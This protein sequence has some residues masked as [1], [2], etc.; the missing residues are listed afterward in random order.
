MEFAIGDIQ[1]VYDQCQP[2]IRRADELGVTGPWSLWVLGNQ[3]QLRVALEH[4]G[5]N[6]EPQFGDQ[7][8]FVVWLHSNIELVA[9]GPGVA[10]GEIHDEVIESAVSFPRCRGRGV[11]SDRVLH[12]ANL[13]VVFGIT[14]VDM[15]SKTRLSNNDQ[16]VRPVLVG[17]FGF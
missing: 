6:A 17:R 2:A 1:R 10:L 3:A 9:K 15:D 4:R 5:L 12:G 13:P 7:E 8:I 11:W 14:H 16:L